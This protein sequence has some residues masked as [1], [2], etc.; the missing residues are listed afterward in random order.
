MA[1]TEWGY[2][3]DRDY[4][5]WIAITAGKNPKRTWLPGNPDEQIEMR[6][7]PPPSSAQAYWW[8]GKHWRQEPQRGIS[9]DRQGIHALKGIL[10]G[11]PVALALWLDF[12]PG[13]WV[14]LVVSALIYRRFEVYETTEDAA[15]RDRSYKDFAGEMIG[16]M[17]M[18]LPPLVNWLWTNGTLPQIL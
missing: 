11:F 3:Q 5:D 6:I 4:G 15:I 7:P 14:S 13:I 1:D 12:L 17:V 8:N 10:V 9:W 16:F 18:V 2:Y